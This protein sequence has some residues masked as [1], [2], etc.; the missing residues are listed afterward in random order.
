MI[1]ILMATYKGEAYVAEQI[2]SIL[3]Q[4]YTDWFL[5]ICDDGSPDG[6]LTVLEAYEERYPDKIRV[7]ENAVNSGS[8]GRNFMGML[9]TTTDDYIMFCDQDDVWLPTK[10][11]MTYRAM[12]R[13]EEKY[14]TKTPL[15][16]HSDLTVV[17]EELQILHPSMMR[18]QKLEGYHRTFAKQLVQ[19]CV[20]GCTVLINRA[21]REKLRVM[22]EQVIM[23]DWWV[24]LV[25]ACFGHIGFVN[26]PLI[27]YRQHGANA[28][29]AK[30]YSGLE[31]TIV[32]AGRKAQIRQSLRLTYEQAREF[33]RIYAEELSVE[34]Y[35][36]LADYCGLANK[37]PGKRLAVALQR[38]FLKT[39]WNRRI[40]HLAYL[41]LDSA[42][43]TNAE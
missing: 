42:P 35:Q 39:G 16:I 27:W 2:E 24:A 33:Y 40:G 3:A 25:A 31:Q 8:A 41:V 19:N 14:G 28:E 38:G 30:D 12:K 21:L 1:Q 4:T 36:V 37:N 6:T 13:M 32:L 29:G 10:I 15:L 11:A 7:R 23:H 9:E 20:T 34:Q 26:V 17:D 5:N 22:P 43:I 18:L